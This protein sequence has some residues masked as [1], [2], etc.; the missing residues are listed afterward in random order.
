M[1][2]LVRAAGALAFLVFPP[3][4]FA[5]TWILADGHTL[6]CEYGLSLS[7][8]ASTPLNAYHA[9]NEL[10]ASPSVKILRRHEGKPYVVAITLH[11]RGYPAST[12]FY[13]RNF[14]GMGMK[15][16]KDFIRHEFDP[17]GLQ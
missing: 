8:E 3:V 17:S 4:A 13:F 2:R 16:C 6:T 11:Q 15:F 10:G 9:E 7:M 5:H 1:K 12:L 14:G